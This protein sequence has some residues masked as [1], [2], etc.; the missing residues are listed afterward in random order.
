VNTPDAERR[1]EELRA[2]IAEGEN[3]LAAL[4]SQR[5]HLVAHLLR[6]SGAVQVLEEL[7]DEPA[8]APTRLRAGSA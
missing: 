6:L 2:Q 3:A 5:E 1:L 7:L 8:S 4:D